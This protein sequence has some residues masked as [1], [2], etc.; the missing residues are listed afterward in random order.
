MTVNY[1]IYIYIGVCSTL[2]L[3]NFVYIFQRKILDFL[4]D[5]HCTYWKLALEKEF[6]HLTTEHSIQK[7]HLKQLEEKLMSIN[8]FTAFIQCLGSF[9]SHPLFEDYL[10]QTAPAQQQ[11]AL[12]Y[13]KKND[14]YKSFY[15]YSISLYPPKLQDEYHP[16]LEILIRYLDSSSLYCRENV[17]KALYSIGNLHAVEMAFQFIHDHQLEHH[18]KLLSD[19]LATFQG[20]KEL[21]CKHLWSHCM[22]WNENLVTS[23]I[24]FISMTSDSFQETFLPVLKSDTTP[25]EVRLEILRYYRRHPYP[26][27]LTELLK[28]M[29]SDC[30]LNLK[31]VSCSVLS[32]YP[33]PDT[34][35]CLKQALKHTN[36]YVRYNAA[37]SLA[38][39]KISKQ[40]LLDIFNGTDT[41]AKEILEY[42][43]EQTGVSI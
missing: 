35:L 25:L 37:Q 2:I 9:E 15:S 38:E 17:L 1:V 11:L 39:L 28:L 6:E 20:N 10:R 14:M 29:N 42:M 40:E 33:S 36:W 27:V 8:H 26:P 43:F 23:I 3:F 31:I 12:K 24:A 19:G 5:R 7:Q 18:Q 30:N 22:D 21:L 13:L 16:L 41:Y 34:I 4:F 32:K